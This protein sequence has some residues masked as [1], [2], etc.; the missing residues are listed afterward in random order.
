MTDLLDVNVWLALVDENHV[1]HER[2]LYYWQNQADSQIAFC[3]VTLLT[4]FRD[5]QRNCLVIKR[6]L[7]RALA[8]SVA[9]ISGL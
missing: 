7:K 8:P 6:S 9:S 3:R 5:R 1:H 4:F 2:A